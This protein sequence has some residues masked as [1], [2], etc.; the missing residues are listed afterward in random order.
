MEKHVDFKLTY[1]GS[2]LD[3]VEVYQ[4]STAYIRFSWFLQSKVFLH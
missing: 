3:I 1:N 4:E 2:L